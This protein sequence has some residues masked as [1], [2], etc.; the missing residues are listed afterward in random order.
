[1]GARAGRV[2]ADRLAEMP[3]LGMRLETEEANYIGGG[4]F[5]ARVHFSP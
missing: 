1:M 2:I 4:E 5:R 3:A